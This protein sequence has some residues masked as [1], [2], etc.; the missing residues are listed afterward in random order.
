[1]TLPGSF[2][3]YKTA[4]PAYLEEAPRCPDCDEELDEEGTCPQCGWDNKPDPDRYRD[5]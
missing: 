5:E 4:T 2:D 3:A 1:M